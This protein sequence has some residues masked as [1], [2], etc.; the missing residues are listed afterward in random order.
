MDSK[1]SKGPWQDKDLQHTVCVEVSD[2]QQGTG[3]GVKTVNC[4]KNLLHKN[5]SKRHI[6]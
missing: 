2:K 5:I 3:K 6:Y 4:K 1:T